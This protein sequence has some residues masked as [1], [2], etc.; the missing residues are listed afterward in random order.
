MGN[1]A[2]LS[3]L[4]EKIYLKAPNF[5]RASRQIKSAKR[6]LKV[7]N[8]GRPI[9]KEEFEAVKEYWKPYGVKP[10]EYWYRL[11]CDGDDSIDPRYIPGDM[12]VNKI[13]P[14]YNN[15]MWG[16]AY[17]DKCAY[18]RP[19]P[20]LNRPRTIVKNA[21][22]RF[23][24]GDQ[25][26]ITRDEAVAL[27]LKEERFIVKFTTFSY[28]G[29]SIHVFEK[30]EISEESVC[31]FFDEY[32]MNFIVQALVEQHEELA[33]LNPTSLNTLRVMSFFFKGKVHIL[34]SQLRIGGEGAR[35]DNYSSDG[36]ACNVNPDGRLNERAINKAGWTTRHPRGFDFK[37]VV[38]P[39]YDKVICTIREEAARL[40][41][42]NIIGW[43]FGVDKDGEP[44]FIELNVYPGQNQRGSG[45]TFGDLTEEV[46]H[47]VFIEK[48]LENAFG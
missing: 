14:Y 45:P 29:K 37:D 21:C 26:V 5:H 2:Q 18:D 40:P 44:V 23:Y 42:L 4:W 7:V 12:W 16:R 10:K 36:F 20:N 47:D 19:F 25:R 11:F 46:L 43:D 39:S 28:G 9:S 17:A 27:C 6:K 33:K 8:N 31:R 30:G 3:V 32:G 35:V 48:S 1:R 13:L 22:G 41:H 34:S 15:L 24:D 38:V